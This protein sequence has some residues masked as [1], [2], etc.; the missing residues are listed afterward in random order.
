MIVPTTAATTVDTFVWHHLSRGHW[1]MMSQ[2]TIFYL[3]KFAIYLGFSQMWEIT[4][5]TNQ[6]TVIQW[7][8]RKS[9]Y[10]NWS[11]F[12]FIASC[13]K[14]LLIKFQCPGITL[15]VESYLRFNEVNQVLMLYLCIETLHFLAILAYIWV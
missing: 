11:L 14:Y 4:S 5:V 6:L 8:K 7:P 13:S 12:Y 15:N 10:N 9:F 1:P 2:I 3:I